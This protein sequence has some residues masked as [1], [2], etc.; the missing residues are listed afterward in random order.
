MARRLTPPDVDVHR[1]QTRKSRV[2][3]WESDV[4]GGPGSKAGLDNDA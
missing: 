4:A 2:N 1:G 3:R